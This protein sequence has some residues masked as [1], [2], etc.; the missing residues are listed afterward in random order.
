MENSFNN[1]DESFLSQRG[2]GVEEMQKYR[3]LMILGFPTMTLSA[4]CRP[5]VEIKIL[6][7]AD[8]NSFADKYEN[9][10]DRKVLKFVPASGAASRMFK[11]LHS[12]LSE[13]KPNKEAT[14]FYEALDR[15]AFGEALRNISS[16]EAGALEYINNLL[17]EEGL[18]YA[19]LPKG[20]ILFHKYDNGEVR[21][22]FE[23]HFYEAAAYANSGGVCHLHFTIPFA[24]E[25]ELNAFLAQAAERIGSKLN[26]SFEV[27]TSIQREASDS[28]AIYA[29]TKA[30]V[31]DEKGQLFFRPAGHGALLTNI[32]DLDADI[33]FVKN[34]DNVVN[35]NLQPLTAEY[36][37]RL[38]GILIFIQDEVFKY[39]RQ[40]DSGN[41]DIE[42]CLAFLQKW[43]G[44]DASMLSEAELRLVLHRPI[45]VCGM[46]KN[47]GEPGG[48]PFLVKEKKG[49]ASLQIVEKAQINLDNPEQK[50]LLDSATHFNPVDLVLGLKDHNGKPY[51]LRQFANPETGMVVEKSY[52]GKSIK[53][54]ELPGLWNGAMHNWNTVF[55]EVPLETFNPVKTVFDLLRPAHC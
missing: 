38:G 12:A 50:S 34:I 15:F 19:A 54:L 55:V 13:S 18:N 41:F 6:S 31:R 4:N 37:K 11:A 10:K 51:D 39:L 21:T 42:P 7:D 9:I 2:I 28:P 47:Q 23:E 49:P 24:F 46:V 8:G 22:A 45:R 14:E 1:K 26:L 5:G 25:A 44:I 30:W 3:E 52:Q 40:M 29:D 48:G 17:S 36:K 32:N 43:I 35:E 33:V 27:G 16:D 53:A 20:S